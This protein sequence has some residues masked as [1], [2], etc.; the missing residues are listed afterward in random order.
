[1]DKV[2]QNSARIYESFPEPMEVDGT[3]HS[4][5]RQNMPMHS[6]R[7]LLNDMPMSDPN[8]W[9]VCEAMRLERL[10]KIV[11]YLHS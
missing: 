11:L 4:N 9:Y 3:N 8:A 7:D 10:F 5:L 1:M 6:R 2:G